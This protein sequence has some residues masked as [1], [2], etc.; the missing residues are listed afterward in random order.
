MEVDQSLITYADIG[1]YILSI[2]VNF[3]LA[4]GNKHRVIV[5]LLFSLELTA[6][7]C[8]FAISVTNS[9]VALVVLFADSLHAL[10]PTISTTTWKLMSFVI[11]I[12]LSFVPLN[13][14]SYTSI[15]G[16]LGTVGRIS[17]LS[18]TNL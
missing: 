3:R 1:W 16:I 6:T 7:W 4:F 9:S 13:I 11:F 10:V 17:P 18:S 14:L 2:I 15:L 8:V 5:S 12:P